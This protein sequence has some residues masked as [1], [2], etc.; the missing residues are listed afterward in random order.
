MR[1]EKSQILEKLAAVVVDGTEDEAK[2]LAQAVVEN[3]MDPLEA[4]EQGNSS[5][6][7]LIF[8]SCSWRRPISMPPWLF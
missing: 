7:R 4:I 6:G 2:T 1:M 8:R 3:Q 5:P